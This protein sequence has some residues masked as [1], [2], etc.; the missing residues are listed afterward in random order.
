[1]A[2]AI[3]GI[4]LKRYVIQETTENRVTF[5]FRSPREGNYYMTVFAQQIGERIKVENIFK[6]ACEYKIVCDQAAGDIRPYPVC[7]DANWGPGAPVKQYGLTPSQTTAIVEAP[8]GRADVSFA[9]S[10]DVRLYARLSKEGIDEATLERAVTIREQDNVIYITVNLPT[11]GEYGLEV[12]ANE[13]SR[14]GDTFTHMCQYL[15]SYTDRDFGSTYGQVFD[16]SD[17]NPQYQASPLQYHPPGATFVAAPGD[18]S[19]AGPGQ[20]PQYG[21][22]PGQGPQYGGPPGGMQYRGGPTHE[23][24]QAAPG[25]YGAPGTQYGGADPKGKQVFST[26][27]KDWDGNTYTEKSY[28]EETEASED[29]SRVYR[30]QTTQVGIIHDKAEEYLKL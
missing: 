15:T 16:R 22:P 29:G 25:V 30:Q 13:P 4:A 3:Q 12:Y 28:R 26:S 9:K 18:Q 17:L 11:R 1:M 21:G 14:E 8:N 19:R 20:G 2:E 6:A 24:A 27:S 5:Y 23:V 10:R 7:S